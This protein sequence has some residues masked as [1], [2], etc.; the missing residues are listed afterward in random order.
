MIQFG[1]GGWRAIIG[2]EFIK[3]NIVRVAAALAEKMRREGVTD[4]GVVLGY[5]K[6]FLSDKAVR[7]IAQVL[8][9]AGVPV[10]WIEKVTPTPVVMYTVAAYQTPYGM[11]VTASHNPAEYNGIKVFT[12][13][14]KD[15]D[16]VV[17]RELEG[18]IAL[19]GD[20]P[21]ID[22]IPFEQG[23]RQGLIRRIYP[24][25]SYMDTIMGMLD[26]E[27][28]RARSLRVLLDPMFGV[29]KVALQTILLT[30]RC[31]VDVIHDSHDTNFG[32]RM[33]S[34]TEDTLSHLR[35]RVVEQ[36]Y[37]LGIGTDGDADRLGIIDEKGR[38][39]HPNR[40][41]CMLYYYLLKYKKWAGPVVRNLATTHQLDRIAEAFGQKSYEV[42]VGFK[43]ISGKMIETN[44]LIGGESS[45]GLTIRGHIHGKDGIFAS[46]LL[47]EMIS[48]TGMRLG[49]M[50][51]LLDREFGACEMV[52]QNC[53][54]TQEVKRRI[55]AQVF[56]RR[57]MAAFSQ[58]VSRI[59][60]L[61]GV[62]VYFENGGWLVGRF[63][64]TEPLL[65]V[66]AEMPD[67]QA[68]HRVI[69]EFTAFLGLV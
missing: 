38:F 39:I 34:P 44:A 32:G 14:G 48:V 54:F 37:D 41:M 57:E 4:R 35:N 31:E 2:D 6:R 33:P 51:A 46:S 50:T 61:D 45:G 27:A 15:A 43:Y 21:Q 16:L 67:A 22:C 29:S 64:G 1:T 56:E 36:G 62:K 12:E 47:I 24:L 66:F 19:Q 8:A 13:G 23:E 55:Q 58:A 9:G 26:M 52:E 60:Y 59:S 5:D 69:R 28:I 11:A 3:S 42:P 20:M 68:A 25:N 7:W 10:Y 49:E 30:C 63:S 65:R 17:T 18:L 53:A 40:I